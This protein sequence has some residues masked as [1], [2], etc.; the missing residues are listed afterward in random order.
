M[1][2]YR[3]RFLHQ[4]IHVLT[5]AF[6]L[7]HTSCKSDNIVTATD[8]SSKVIQNSSQETPPVNGSVKEKTTWEGGVEKIDSVE[9]L[10]TKE[11]KKEETIALEKPKKAKNKKPAKKKSKKKAKPKKQFSK[12]VFEELEYDFGKITEGDTIAHKF[13]FKNDSKIPL[14][15]TSA[16]AT[17]GCTRPSFPFIAIEPGEEGYIGVQYISINKEGNQKPEITVQSNGSPQ[18]I[19]LYLTGYVEPKPKKEDENAVNLD[20]IIPEKLPKKG[21]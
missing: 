4:F 10:M 5:L 16:D 2:F 6:L 1:L 19:T 8:N 15:I 3:M 9:D 14:E 11:V 18:P 17:C 7:L 13:I 21:N 12:I 20:S